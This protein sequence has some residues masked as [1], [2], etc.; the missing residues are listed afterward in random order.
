M[1]VE[2]SQTV[3]S[4]LENS[5]LKKL[6][7]DEKKLTIKM[8]LS[9][10]AWTY[11]TNIRRH[12]FYVCRNSCLWFEWTFLLESRSW[13]LRLLI[14][15][16]IVLTNVRNIL[17]DSAQHSLWCIRSSSLLNSLNQLSNFLILIRVSAENESLNSIQ[18]IRSSECVT[19][20]VACVRRSQFRSLS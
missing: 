7:F 16:I 5:T 14:T 3:R 20:R 13:Q 9:S 6:L 15:E 8:S 10:K 4:H 2:F 18:R 12:E 19:R 11:S 17:Q 1:S